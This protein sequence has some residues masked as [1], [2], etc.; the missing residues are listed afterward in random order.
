M[1]ELKRQ[2]LNQLL[3]TLAP[4]LMVDSAWLKAQ[5]ISR[6]SVHDY[7]RRGWLERVSS[8]VY[9][10]PS[11]SSSTSMLR[12]DM[13]VISAQRYGSAAFHVGGMTALELLGLGHF[14]R[15][16]TNRTIHLYDAGRATPAWLA[17]L[18]LDAEINVHTRALFADPTLGIDWHRLDPGTM[19]LGATVASPQDHEPWDHFLRVAGPE[20]A[21][22]EMLDDVPGGLTFDHADKI[23]ENLTTLRPK[24]L[25]ELLEGCAS[26]RAKRLFLFFAD[27]HDHGWA[28]RLDREHIDIGRGKRQLVPNGR[29]DARYQITVPLALAER[30]GDTGQ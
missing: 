12:W 21:A 7:V 8:R 19:R 1:D 5:G 17:R 22:I 28:R 20:R 2:P 27:R 15:L 16:G 23:F 3:A 11:P 18:P 10:R 25:T 14:A 9:R 24:M 6:T 26:V 4:G 13:A 29:F 30:A